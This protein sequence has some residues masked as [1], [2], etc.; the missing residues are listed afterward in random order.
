[1]WK[2]MG[3]EYLLEHHNGLQPWYIVRQLQNYNLGIRGANP[4]D[5]Y[6]MQMAPLVQLLPDDQALEDVAAYVQTLEQ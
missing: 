3:R 2:G 6:G 5:I 4:K 1:M